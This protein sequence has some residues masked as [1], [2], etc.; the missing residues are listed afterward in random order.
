MS[1][2]TNRPRRGRPRKFQ[3]DVQAG[4]STNDIDIAASTE[5]AMEGIREARPA[6]VRDFG[7]IERQPM[8]TEMRPNNGIKSA[9]ERAAEIMQNLGGSQES[10]D[11]F[12]IPPGYEPDGWTYEWKRKTIHNQEDPAY[13]VSLSRTGWEPVPCSRHPDMMPVGWKGMTIE[14][15]GMILMTRPK[16][17]TEYIRNLDDRRAR[18]QVRAK[19]EQLRSAPDGQFARDHAQAQ[20]KIRKSFE[21]MP[22]PNE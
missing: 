6:D 8:R 2:I 20:P 21:A 3:S 1:E 18:Y 16:Q 5:K 15:D 13:Q 14:R 11:K 4:P 12:H 7:A 10:A 19:E 17:V 22:I 9:E